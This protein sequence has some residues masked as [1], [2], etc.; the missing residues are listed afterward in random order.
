MS[1]LD[2]LAAAAASVGEAQGE[3]NACEC[4]DADAP[5]YDTEPGGQYARRTRPTHTKFQKAVMS[6]YFAFNKLPDAKE[7]ASVGLAIGLSARA[8]QVWFQNRRQRQKPAGEPMEAEAGGAMEV[9]DVGAAPEGSNIDASCR[10]QRSTP[11][12][13]RWSN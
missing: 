10:A 4:T 7:R 2:A 11:M 9:S 12:P 13:C 3:V 1:L 5:Q 6:S 8:V